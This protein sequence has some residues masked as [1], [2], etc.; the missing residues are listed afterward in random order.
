MNA[1]REAHRH[2]LPGA[3]LDALVPVAPTHTASCVATGQMQ[4]AVDMLSS[5]AEAAEIA[6][7]W[8]RIA[9]GKQVGGDYERRK[10]RRALTKLQQACADAATALAAMGEIDPEEAAIGNAEASAALTEAALAR[11]QTIAADIYDGRAA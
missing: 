6:A 3:S 4:V 11:G 5:A 1:F 7:S 2:L 9:S 8:A 10:A